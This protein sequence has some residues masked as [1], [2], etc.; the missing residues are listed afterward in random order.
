MVIAALARGAA[1]LEAH[2]L[3]SAQDDP[4]ALADRAV[5]RNFDAKV[6]AREI[7]A[8]L[9]A[10][11]ADLANSFLELAR[12]QNVPVEPALAAKVEA[13]DAAADS[14]GRTCENFAK[15][16]VTGEPDDLVGLAGTAVGDLFVIGDIRDAVREGT[17]LAAGQKADEL[18]L[19]LACVG[20]AVTAGHLRVAR[21]SAPARIG[22]TR[23][24]GGAQDRPDHRAGWPTGSA[25]RCAKSSTGGALSARSATPRIAQP[26]LAVRAVRE[27]VKVEKAEGLVK[28]VGDVGRVQAQGR[29]A[30]GARRPQDRAWSARHGQGRDARRRPRAARPARSSSSPA[31]ARSC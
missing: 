10:K 15:G 12:E 6:A 21:R 16:L 4:V 14:A 2:W 19:G 8:A 30:G 26:A 17:R 13:A 5:S 28:L 18:I 31:A 1:G 24:Q 7:E 20:L 9:A 27:A 3:I 11:D 29:H 23:G 25:D 22:L